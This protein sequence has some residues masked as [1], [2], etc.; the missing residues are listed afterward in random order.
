MEETNGSYSIELWRAEDEMDLL[1]SELQATVWDELRVDPDLETCRND[2]SVYVTGRHVTLIG[3]VQRFTQKAAAWRA[4]SRVPGVDRVTNAIRVE[5]PPNDVRS[6]EMIAEEVRHVL[7]WDAIV[8]NDR[9]SVTVLEGLVT[10]A[11]EVDREH[12]RAAAERA[13]EPLIGITGIHNNV[14]V[15]AMYASGN[16]QTPVLAAIRRLRADGVHVEV[17]GGTV[18]LRGRVAT[19]ADRERIQE[20]IREVPGVTSVED[21]LRIEV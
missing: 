4:T 21:R 5:L 20:A 11:G 8:P 3:F 7:N 1:A 2:L 19:L 10:L 6:D 9:I 14:T 18:E 13:V 17:H 12:Q 16:V 15:R